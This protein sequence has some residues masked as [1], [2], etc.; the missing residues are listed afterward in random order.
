MLGHLRHLLCLLGCYYYRIPDHQKLHIGNNQKAE[1]KTDH[2]YT[3]PTH[4][5]GFGAYN[6]DFDFFMDSGELKNGEKLQGKR[7][8]AISKKA[9]LTSTNG[10]IK[11]MK[12]Q[13]ADF[14]F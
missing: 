3:A 10:V 4:N 2:S 7:G 14:M 1:L 6:H 8:T 9:V 5:I 13:N 11:T 12:K